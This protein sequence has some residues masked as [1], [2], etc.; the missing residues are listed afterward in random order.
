MRD[1]RF[2]AYRA[3]RIAGG[4]QPPAPV[5]ETVSTASAVGGARAA[6]IAVTSEAA[7]VPEQPPADVALC[8]HRSIGNKSCTRPAGHPQASHRYS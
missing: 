6:D 4:G 3:S 2:A 8:G 5:T 1:A 7:A